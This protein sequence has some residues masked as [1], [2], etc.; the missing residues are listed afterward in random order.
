LHEVSKTT[1]KLVYWL[2]FHNKKVV[3]RSLKIYLFYH[4]AS[5]IFLYGLLGQCDTEMQEGQCKEIKKRIQKTMKI[6]AEKDIHTL[7]KWF[8]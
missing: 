1:K 3:K 5:I 4:L 6:Y 7:F 8:Y 2:T